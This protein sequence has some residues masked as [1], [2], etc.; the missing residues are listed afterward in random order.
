VLVVLAH[1][2]T[3]LGVVQHHLVKIVEELITSLVVALDL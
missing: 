2:L 1:Q 3:R